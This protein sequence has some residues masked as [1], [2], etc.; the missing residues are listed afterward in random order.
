MQN[1]L[2][3]SIIGKACGLHNI[4]KEFIMYSHPPVVMLLHFLF[5]VTVHHGFI[6]DSFGNIVRVP[7]V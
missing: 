4:M 6:P 5:N 7:A 1:N 2:E 3:D